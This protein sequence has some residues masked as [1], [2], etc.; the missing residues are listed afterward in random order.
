MAEF[1]PSRKHIFLRMEDTISQAKE[2]VYLISPDLRQ[3]PQ[4]V[5]N[6]L[7]DAHRRGVK[8]FVLYRRCELAGEDEV[9]KLEQLKGVSIYRH[10]HVHVNTVFSEKEA[11]V[12]SLDLTGPVEESNV[13]FGIYFRKSYA[14]EMHEKLLAESKAIRLQGV[15]MAMHQGT[16][17]ELAKIEIPL[18]VEADK[19][20]P[21]SMAAAAKKLTPREKQNL[22]L[23]LFSKECQGCVVKV[24]DHERMRLQGK[25]IVV[26]TNKERVELIF[27]RYEHY[28]SKKEEVKAYILSQHPGLKVWV[29]YNRITVNAERSDDIVGLFTTV[30][31]AVTSLSLV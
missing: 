14:A 6:K 3:I 31:N 26:F 24:E 11:V 1:L 21:S 28:N 23:E 25:G 8:I 18:P 19:V 9:V 29:T 4:T 10:E 22:I 30:K 7:W 2:L 12:T 27:V 5:F 20:P 15:K 13:E 17:V 16:L